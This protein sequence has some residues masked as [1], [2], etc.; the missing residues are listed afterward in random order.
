MKVVCLDGVPHFEVSEPVLS[1]ACLVLSRTADYSADL[2]PI[3]SKALTDVSI[4]RSIQFSSGRRAA[5]IALEELQIEDNAVGRSGR[6]PIWPRNVVGSISHSDRLAGAL[7]GS[8][9][10]FRGLGMDLVPIAAVSSNVAQR[11]LTDSELSWVQDT[12]SGDWRTALFSA[13]ESVYKA[14]NP[15]VGE[16]LGFRDVTVKVVPDS[17]EFF[18]STIDNRESTEL[19]DRGRGY[20]H[21]VEGHWLTIFV[22]SQ[23]TTC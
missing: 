10:Y 16:Y 5:H 6:V 20:I 18:A 9:T 12:G 13:K 19:V 7:V 23:A 22:V 2:K 17:L 14:V 3:E 21:R 15:V 4:I 8:S 1:N 11:L